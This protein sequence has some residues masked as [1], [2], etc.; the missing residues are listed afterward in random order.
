MIPV[1]ITR[2]KPDLITVEWP[3]GFKATITLERLRAE[4][5][6]AQC[7]GEELTDKKHIFPKLRMFKPGM[8]ELVNLFPVG[9]YAVTAI[10]AD[11]HDTGIYTW[12]V[13]REIFEKYALPESE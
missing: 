2:P 8:N 10:W 1:S 5:P 4:C 3:D 7:Q 11:G 6:C 9:N 12:E 13:L